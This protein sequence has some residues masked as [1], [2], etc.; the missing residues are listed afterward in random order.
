MD[1][2]MVARKIG[3][4]IQV[5]VNIFSPYNQLLSPKSIDNGSDLTISFS[6]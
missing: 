2:V 5:V 6:Y 3:S 1:S 4:V